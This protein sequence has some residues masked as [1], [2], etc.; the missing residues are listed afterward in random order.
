MVPAGPTAWYSANQGRHMMRQH[1]WWC[2]LCWAG[3]LASAAAQAPSSLNTQPETIPLTTPAEAL[4]QM[5]VPQGFHVELFAHEPMVQQPIAFTTD[6]RGRL[7]VAEN[8]TYAESQVNFAADQRDRLVILEDADGD[9]RCDRR[10]V[11]WDAAQKL[12]SVEVGF[13][14]VWALCAPH[15]L[16]IPDVDR[17]DV[18]D[19]PPVV[20]LDGWDAHAVRHNIVNGLKWGPDGWLY[21]RHGILATSL[22][23]PPGSAPSQRQAIN[24]G[25]WRFHPTRRVFETVAHGT[26]NPW[27]FDYDEHGEMFFIN[28]VIGHLW[29]VVPGA[30]YRRMYGSDF[31]PY[32]FGLIEQTA[33]HFHWDT[34]EAWNDIRKLGVSDTTSAAGGGHAHSGL[35]I[36]QGDNWPAQYRGRVLTVNLHGRRLNCDRLER[37]LAGFTAR[38]EADFLFAGDPWF[39]GIDLLSGPDGGVYLAD[40]SDIGECHENDGVHR[41]SGRIYK[42]TYGT[43]QPLP[44]FDMAEWSAAQLTAALAHPNDWWARQARRLL[45]ER[46]AAGRDVSAAKS[47]L[48]RRVAGTEAAAPAGAASAGTNG[49]GGEASATVSPRAVST[50]V[51]RLRALWSL[52]GLQAVGPTDLLDLLDDGDEHVRAWAV[53]LLTD[54]PLSSHSAETAQ[55]VSRHLA[56]LAARERSGLVQLYLASALQRLALED[57]W[58]VAAPLMSR[59][60]FADDRALPLLLWYGLEPAVAREP[61]RA[62]SLIPLTP[63]TTL[64]RYLARRITLAIEQQPGGVE[65]LLSRAVMVDASVQRNILEGMV[66][67]LR[68]W[69]RAPQ[70]RNWST[71]APILSGLGREEHARLVRELSVVF[72]D[73]RAVDELRSLVLQGGVD[74]ASRQQALRTLV[75]A[76]VDDL[77]PLLHKLLDDRDVMVEA[78]RGL[79][80]VEHPSNA[81][82]I[83]ERLPRLS[84]EGR[85]IALQTLVSRPSTARALLEAVAD[86]RVNRRELTAFHAR[87]ILD[88]ND[89]GL[90]ERLQQVW[91]DIRSSSAEKRAVME[92]WKASLTEERLQ[93]ANRSAGRAL[94]QKTCA[95]CHVLFG[96]GKTVGPDLTGGNRRNLDYLLENMIDPSATVAADFRMTVFALKD[97]RVISGVVVEAQEKTLEVQTPTERLVLARADVEESRPTTQSLMPEGLLQNLSADEVRDLV[98]Y[99]MSSE[100]VPLP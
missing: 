53:R 75:S 20:M 25:I 18:P 48:L 69:S 37:E 17:N 60:E 66:E 22:V 29:H 12:T 34:R 7:W 83:L 56:K 51:L 62:A 77:G 50:T 91:G 88:F 89:A 30:H 13:G 31:S 74:A 16:F 11:F 46:A 63:M 28:T 40:W 10:V 52:W 71:V 3:M 59:A 23:G 45:Q 92:Q 82:K 97:G 65:A 100:Q 96:S 54:E 49:G 41:T 94:F 95:N 61:E 4:R 72:G 58:A 6:E 9:G 35:M 64:Q 55:T 93:Q 38:H 5:R 68:G 27:G 80:A 8:Y 36:Y 76:K 2:S 81:A 67:A 86:G 98:G 84:P 15:L 19:G 90:A 78:I 42:I 1:A 79:A 73:G 57:R 21:G 33:D 44:A 47:Q 39:R 87:Q 85:A 32:L 14:G 43:P 70:P 99:L 26:T 24:C